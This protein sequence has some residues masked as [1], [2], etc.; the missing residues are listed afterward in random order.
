M[1]LVARHADPTLC[2]TLNQCHGRGACVC[3]FEKVFFV[4]PCFK[5]E[6]KRK[7]CHFA[8]DEFIQAVLYDSC[9]SCEQRE[10]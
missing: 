2:A 7:D 4:G 9:D 1:S 3:L 6:A 5:R 8:S 10:V